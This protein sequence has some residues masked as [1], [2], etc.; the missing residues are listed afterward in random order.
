M[1]V[2]EVMMYKNNVA[3]QADG[4]LLQLDQWKKKSDEVR[5]QVSVVFL[6]FHSF[7]HG[8][9][10]RQNCICPNTSLPGYIT[11]LL[12]FP[13]LYGIPVCRVHA[14]AAAGR[15]CTIE[16]CTNLSRAG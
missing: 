7:P 8:S 16:K 1:D 13:F 11:D 5:S 2:N 9:V 12:L 14:Q 3:L 6:D 4:L 15:K 10:H